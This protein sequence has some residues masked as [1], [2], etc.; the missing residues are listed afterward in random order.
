[1]V[2]MDGDLLDIVCPRPA[3]SSSACGDAV[4]SPSACCEGQAAIPPA[5]PPAKKVSAADARL[6]QRPKVSDELARRSQRIEILK[7]ARLAKALK[8]LERRAAPEAEDSFRCAQAW[9]STQLHFGD[10]AAR[11]AMEREVKHKLQFSMHGASK[12]AYTDAMD[13]KLG[14]TGYV[15]VRAVVS[16]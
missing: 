10:Q 2:V 13:S 14:S 6:L 11:S 8:Q 9:D 7:R 12:L 5:L 4:A 16:S 1:M 15:P 3:S